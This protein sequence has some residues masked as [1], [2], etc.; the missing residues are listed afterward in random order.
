MT[1]PMIID[2]DPGVDDAVAIMLAAASPEVQLLAV[3]TVFGNAGVEITTANALRLRGLAGL[4]NLPV[5]AGAGRPLVYPP[6]R[7]T[8]SRH[9]RDG[10]GGHADLLGAPIGPVNTLGAVT[11]M[12]TLLR[13]AVAPVTLVA[14]GP[15]T[16]I[17]L[18]LA[19][20]PEVK[21]RIDRIVIMGGNLTGPPTEFNISS[22]PEA[23]RRVLVEEDVATT[24]VP[25]DVTLHI[26]VDG[27][28]IAELA[29]AGPRCAALAAVLAH[30]REQR[31]APMA[32]HDSVAMLAAVAPD[33]LATTPMTLQ[34]VCD[35]GSDRG[36]VLAA[37]EQQS[38]THTVQVVRD[39]DGRSINA[40]ILNRL[41]SLQ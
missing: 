32:L 30:T 13:D 24:L 11:L 1:V 14:I 3:T 22:D 25:L 21:P 29:A 9:G 4:G 5:A 35:H 40:T 17:A 19:V 28:W 12:A 15:L 6:P 31:R 37:G 36:A 10:L 18:L 39:G 34:V 26:A 23:A 2:T 16:N 41:R 27:A 8:D 38:A 33:T 7:R 20:H